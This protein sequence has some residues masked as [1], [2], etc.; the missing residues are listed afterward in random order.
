MLRI[1]RSDTAKGIRKDPQFV[2]SF[3]T[4]L[5]IHHVRI[6]R[7]VF[8][9]N[10][11]LRSSHAWY[12]SRPRWLYIT[13]SENPWH[14]QTEGDFSIVVVLQD[15]PSYRDARTHLKTAAIF[16]FLPSAFSVSTSPSL[17]SCSPPPLF[18]AS[19]VPIRFFT[20]S[21]VFFSADSYTFKY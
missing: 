7:E 2:I 10:G 20:A 5:W 17:S 4:L 21:I 14:R 11:R 18:S 16:P 15:T 8:S 19:D 9:L 12:R 6:S 13:G 1:T 3:N